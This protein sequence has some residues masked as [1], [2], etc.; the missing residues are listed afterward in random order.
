[1]TEIKLVDLDSVE[2]V[3]EVERAFRIKIGAGEAEACTSMGDLFSAIESKI[4]TVER[5]A[6]P[7]P[8]ALAFW[9]LRKAMREMA[10]GKA[11]TPSTPV[12]DL[13]PATRQ[14]R[15]WRELRHSTGLEMPSAKPAKGAW[16][17]R[18]AAILAASLLGGLSFAVGAGGWS[19]LVGVI[20]YVVLSFPRGRP[21][22]IGMDAG[23]TVGDLAKI[24]ASLNVGLLSERSGSIRTR[25]AW[26]ALEGVVRNFTDYPGPIDKRTKFECV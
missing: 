18:W 24:A 6:L 26:E 23:A 11:I 25:E 20:V 4:F 17:P 8:A 15:W 1:M 22:A 19:M 16:P 21:N 14:G 7:C 2:I 10:S 9:R 13:L 3:R 12:A 5:G